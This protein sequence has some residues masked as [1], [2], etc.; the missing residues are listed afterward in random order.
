MPE[1]DNVKAILS[2]LDGDPRMA[3]IEPRFQVIIS[4]IAKVFGR[5]AEI[6]GKRATHSYG[7]TALGVIEGCQNLAIP[8][9]RLFSSDLKLPVLVRHANIKGFPDDAILDGRGATVRI[10]N[11]PSDNSLDSIAALEDYAVDILMSTGSCFILNNAASFS[12]WVAADLEGRAKLLDEFPK[13]KPI[14]NEII[15]NPHSY[16]QLYYY[17]ETTYLFRSDDDEPKEYFL[18]YRLINADRSGDSGFIPEADVRMPLDFLPRLVDDFR[19][20]NYLRQDFRERVEEGKVKYILQFQLREVTEL[21]TEN[22]IAKDC[23]IAWDEKQYPFHDVAQLSLKSIV[24]DAIA[25]RLEFNAYHAPQDLSLILAHSITETASINHLRSVVYQISADM[26]KYLVPSAELVDWGVAQQPKLQQVFPYFVSKLPTEGKDLPRFDP[27]LDLPPRV[28]PKPRLAAN[29]GLHAIPAR[30]VPPPINQLGIAG[31]TEFLQQIPQPTLMPANL[32]RTRPDKFTDHFFVERRLNG[33]NPGKFNYVCDKPWQYV[34]CFDCSKHQIKPSGILPSIIEARFVLEDQS[35]KVHSIQYKLDYQTITNCPG[36]SD[37]NL[38]KRLFR[39]AEFVFQETQSHLARTHLN[40][41]QYAMAYYRNVVDHPIRLLLEPHF[42]GLLNVNKLGAS[43]IF[44]DTGIIPECSVLDATQVEAL[45]KE[46]VAELSYKIWSPETQKLKDH[47][48]NN[49][50]DPAA[51]A[52]WDIIGTYVDDFF[53]KHNHHICSLWSEIEKMSQDLVQHSILD[54][55][56]GTLA[57]TNIQDLKKLCVYVIYTSSFIHSWVN[58]K[59]YEDGGDVD[60]AALGLWDSH[61][62]AYNPGAITQRH[63]KQVLITWTLSSVKYNPI[64]ENGSPFLKDLLW[65][66]RHEIEPGMPLENIMMS[67]HI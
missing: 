64:M 52:V 11:K 45:L 22:E 18:R 12:R 41:E 44:G 9:H 8:K 40:I 28:A 33:F 49:Y 35:L 39:S 54:P 19:P 20:P 31:I 61:D 6:K 42:E 13:I 23:T 37:W 66:R 56:L 16:T 51:L 50:Y 1:N 65:K 46:E 57:I 14:F 59:Q 4:N 2:G 25:E 36:D 62:P 26:R 15:R 38:A 3:N 10:L 60:Y 48:A 47:V 27:D 53:D 21:E 7:V 43:I 55:K 34:I 29:I 30:Q 17:S 58:Y 24:P 5:F 32:T 63:I 67:I